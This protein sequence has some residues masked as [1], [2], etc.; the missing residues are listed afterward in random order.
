M[1]LS[2]TVAL[3][4]SLVRI[5]SVTPEDN[6][7]QKLVSEILEPL[8]CK[9][10]SLCDSGTANLIVM[11]GSGSPFTLFL[12]HTDVV[13]A[14]ERK[15]W[16]HE[17][18]CGDILEYDGEMV[19]YGR[20][21]A[22]MKGGD[23]AMIMAMHDYIVKNPEHKGT[24]ALLLTSNEEGD[25]KGATPF[26]V[27]NF[28]KKNNLIPDYCLI[29]ECSSDEYF[30]DS[31]KNGRRG[32]INY[33]IVV[34]GVQGHIA[35]EQYASNAVHAAAALIKALEDHPIDNGSDSFPPTS[36]Q[37][38]NIHAGTGADNVIP[39]VCTLRCNSRYNDLQ[40]VDSV[41]AHVQEWI[42]KLNLKCDVSFQ[43]DGEPFITRG[44]RLIEVL[45]A[46]ISEV[47]KVKPSLG[48]SG[49][50]SDGRFIRPLGTQTVEFGPVAKTIHKANER[51][52][53]KVLDDLK[54]IFY[55]TLEEL[56][57]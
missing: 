3:A 31:I 42:D 17:P 5:P 52:P 24:I 15:A 35:Q 38:S 53:I 36:F 22:D 8:G 55:L 7:C 44:G 25:A 32:D 26:V 12:G 45:S 20:G 11:H 50:T 48:S 18:F 29:G 54:E 4:Q 1:N 51:V 43:H 27:D 21:S 14:G 46:K 2:K 19:L 39:G 37:V 34:H 56:H 47:L 40:T 57:K 41:K 16:D 30:G 9:C 6:G 49:G 33:T 23:A 10:I 28:L 13:P